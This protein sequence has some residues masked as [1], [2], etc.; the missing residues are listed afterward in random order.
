M[1]VR[2]LN[3]LAFVCCCA[4]NVDVVHS[5]I[6]ILF[7]VNTDCLK[8]QA[9]ECKVLSRMRGVEFLVAAMGTECSGELVWGYA[10]SRGN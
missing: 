4:D 3:I 8:R 7:Y 10:I 2:E 6:S 5:A 1:K 9:E